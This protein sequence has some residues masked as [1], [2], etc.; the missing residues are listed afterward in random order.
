M[1]QN[2][3]LRY[4]PSTDYYRLLGVSPAATTDEIRQAFRR[5]AKEVHP[6][7]NPTRKDWAHQQFQQINIA[8]DV[9]TDPVQRAEYDR[10]RYW[11]L[12]QAF[13]AQPKQQA[14][15]RR[16]WTGQNSAGSTVPR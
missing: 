3:E 16:A 10:Q 8:H 13:S 15:A 2:R 14:S 9:L 1:S 7:R 11:Y 5:R 12:R 4:N 6:D